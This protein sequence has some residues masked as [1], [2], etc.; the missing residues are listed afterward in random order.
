MT[1]SRGNE[2]SRITWRV[3]ENAPVITA[4][5][6]ITVATVRDQ[7]LV[8]PDPRF[9]WVVLRGYKSRPKQIK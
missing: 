8:A 9:W 7:G 4:W 2:L 6:A 3:I 5:L 1:C